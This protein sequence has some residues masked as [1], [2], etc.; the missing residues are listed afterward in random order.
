[1]HKKLA[2]MLAR[3]AQSRERPERSENGER[4]QPRQTQRA[5]GVT[6]PAQGNSPP[7]QGA[8]LAARSPSRGI[9][10]APRTPPTTI[11]EAIAADGVTPRHGITPANVHSTQHIAYDDAK[12][13]AYREDLRER[14]PGKPAP[15]Q[16]GKWEKGSKHG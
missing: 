13:H 14:A 2:E 15:T 12:A 11:T 5:R 10:N 9:L 3:M 8:A 1:M 7:P 16:Q 6:P 4:S